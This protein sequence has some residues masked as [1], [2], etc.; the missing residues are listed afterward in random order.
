MSKY[1]I[2]KADLATKEEKSMLS[3]LIP[4]GQGALDEAE[5]TFECRVPMRALMTSYQELK[6]LLW[7]RQSENYRSKFSEDLRF[8][9]VL[10]SCYS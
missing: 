10:A 8:L 7:L 4:F 3:P 9:L 5:F 6:L 2:T 1:M